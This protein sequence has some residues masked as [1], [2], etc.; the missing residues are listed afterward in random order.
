MR[1]SLRR[2]AALPCDTTILSLTPVTIHSGSQ[3]SPCCHDTLTCIA[4]QCLS[5][6]T[7]TSVMIQ[8]L[9]R[10][11]S[12][13]SQPSLLSQYS[14]L[15]RDLLSSLTTSSLLRYNFCP[16]AIQFFQPLHTQLLCHDTIS[17]YHDTV[18]QPHCMP[19]NAYVTI[20]FFYHNTIGQ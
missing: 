12:Y 1:G 18:P 6:T 17:L 3:A 9:Y 15:Y 2:V 5:Q 4:T 7:T 8:N 13:P 19:K 16:I 20:Q 10:D 14:P 11:S